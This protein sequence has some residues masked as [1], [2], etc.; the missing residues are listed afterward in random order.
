MSDIKNLKQKEMLP[1][2]ADLIIEENTVYEIDRDCYTCRRQS[3][4]RRGNEKE[5]KG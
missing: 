1:E 5:K 3:R 2:E 4:N